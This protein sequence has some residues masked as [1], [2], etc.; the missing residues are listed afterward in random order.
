M[1]DGQEAT[2][3][4]RDGRRVAAL[5][6]DPALREDR[7]VLEAVT[8]AAA[9][10]LDNQ[11]LAAAVRAQ[12]VEVRASRARIVAAADEQRRRVERDL[13]D[14]A[15]Q[16]LVTVALLLRLASQR[17]DELPD[18]DETL[19]GYLARGAEGLED[20][21]RELRELARGIH[22]AVLSEAGLVPALNALAA[23]SPQP[24]GVA[25]VDTAAAADTGR[26]DRVLRRGRGGDQRAQTRRRGHDQHRRPARRRHVVP[27]GHRRRRGGANLAAGTGLLG[28]RDRASALGGELVVR[29]TEGAGTT[30]RVVLPLGT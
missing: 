29:S 2:V 3:V 22:P 21:V 20:A 13:H 25:G 4:V 1:P 18:R 5:L 17:L 24:V 9:L 11:R 30:V 15:Q 12:L 28:L 14:G 23:R 19:A 6:H 8:S 7:H 27:R 26:G 16:Q 10:E